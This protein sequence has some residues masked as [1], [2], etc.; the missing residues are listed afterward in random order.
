MPWY[1]YVPG[2]TI[3]PGAM[4]LNFYIQGNYSTA[5]SNLG[6]NPGTFQLP[7]DALPFGLLML[8]SKKVHVSN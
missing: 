8:P 1:S 3:G 4:G 7:D 2:F 5:S 6:I